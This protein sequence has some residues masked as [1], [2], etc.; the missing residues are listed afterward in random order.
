MKKKIMDKEGFEIYFEALE[1]T[2]RVEDW[3]SEEDHN[4]V[5]NKIESGEFVLFC[6]KVTAEKA[7][8]E[9]ASD[10]LG[11]CVYDS[12]EQFYTNLDGSVAET[13]YFGDMVKAVLAEAQPALLQLIEELRK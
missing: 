1:D 11:S 6:A 7:G 4:D 13:G 10:Y 8:I 3:D 12:E 5:C 2:T 9:L